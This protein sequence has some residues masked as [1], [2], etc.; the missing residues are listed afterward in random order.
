MGRVFTFPA[1]SLRP[2]CVSFCINFRNSVIVSLSEKE[3]EKVASL[4]PDL[5]NYQSDLLPN[6]NGIFLCL[7]IV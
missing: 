1:A 4:V 7:Y 2:K 5:L 6:E 3:M